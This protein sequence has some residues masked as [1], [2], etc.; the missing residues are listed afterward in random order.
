MPAEV[1]VKAIEIAAQSGVRRLNYVEGILRNWL[2][3]GVRNL[4]DIERAES[5]GAE[6]TSCSC[7]ANESL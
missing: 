6:A 2:N 4:E 7:A 1:V 3:D 5:G